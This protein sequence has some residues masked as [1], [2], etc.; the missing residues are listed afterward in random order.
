MKIILWVIIAVLVIVV[1]CQRSALRESK[2]A[3]KGKRTTI[4]A[5]FEEK[6]KI[7]TAHQDELAAKNEKITNLEVRR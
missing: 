6:A 1:W 2:A 4:S 5:L 7:E 3:L